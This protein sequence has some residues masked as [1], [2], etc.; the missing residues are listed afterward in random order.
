MASFEDEMTAVE[1]WIASVEDE[2]TK[3]CSTVEGGTATKGGT[4]AEDGTEGTVAVGEVLILAR[5]AS[6]L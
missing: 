6:E 2:A 1:V 3:G 5:F 4:L